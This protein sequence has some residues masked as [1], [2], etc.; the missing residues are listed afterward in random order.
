MVSL[1]TFLWGILPILQK[2]GLK[3]FSPGTVVWFR[4]LFAFFL[5]YP[6]LHFRRSRP[7]SIIVRPPLW[8]LAAGVCLAGN[9]FGVITGIHYSSPS[10]AAVI[11]QIAP[12]LLVIVGVI[13]FKEGLTGKQIFGFAVASAGFLVFYIDQRMHTEDLQ[14]Y[15]TANAY[16]VFGAVVW[17]VFMAIQKHLSR[18]YGA[19]N[20]NL[21]IYG[22]A[23]VTLLP[24]VHWQEF[25]GV[26]PG[27]WLLI[28]VLGLNTLLAY[29][30]LAEAIR[31]IPLT[32][33]S[34]ITALNPLLTV[35]LMQ[36]LKQM[37]IDWVTPENMGSAG[38]L[39]AVAAVTGVVLVVGKK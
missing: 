39:G 33:I 4:F 5:L 38:W 34:V 28:M 17:V 32:Y 24:A 10:N 22:T 18:E 37:N 11:V 8:G 2:I 21:L 9:Y 29:G 15:S 6:L 7:Q 27:Y 3:E 12:V 23:A 20:L 30:A 16:I 35:S 13:F 26:S 14:L 19:Q 25:S 1:T 31:C 36:G